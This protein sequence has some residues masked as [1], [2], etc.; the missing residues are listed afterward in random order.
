MIRGALDL[1]M[2]R[3]ISIPL[4]FSFRWVA[5]VRGSSVCSISGAL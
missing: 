2:H 1:G 5:T 4:T 3:E